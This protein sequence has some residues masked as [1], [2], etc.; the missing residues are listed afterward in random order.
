MKKGWPTKTL[1]EVCEVFADGDWVE[2]KDQSSEGI[3]LIQTGNVGEGVFK[4]RA[5]K[6]RYISDATFKRLR[7]TEIVEGDCLVSRLPDPVGRSC[8][9]PD[10]GERMITAVD[11]T[12]LR[13]NP[14]QL[15]PTFFN[16]YSQSDDYITT[17]AKECTGTTRNRI[18]RSNLGLTPIPVPPLAEQ[19]RIVGLLDEA[20]E[21]IATAK[22]NAEKNLQNARALFESHLQSVFTQRG[23]GWV[24]KPFED[25]I[26]D[27]KYTT[28]IQRKEFLEEG[29]FP[30]VSQEAEFTNGYWDNAA[31][32]F[33]VTRPVV[34]FGD[35]TQ[36]LKYIDFD[37]VLG[38]DGVKLLPP[39]PFLNPKFFFYALRSAPLKSLGYARH[40]RLLKELQ[41]GYPDT[42]TQ[43]SIAK[44]LDALSEETQRLAR[45]YERKHAA[46]DALK[47]SL[48]HQAFSGAL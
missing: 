41:I 21:G 36:V 29:E 15:L 26:E 46:L 34:I 24:E 2:S 47:K 17:V 48:L 30:I 28:K 35:H 37:F 8:I 27:V 31:D 32:V 45:L 19:Q 11:C 9:L 20:F 44:K 39:K 1:G 40:Y 3:R 5:E 6:A 16:L 42:N 22:A 13:F 23:P 43:V 7:C 25:C 33:K 12:I 14:K 4:D 10:T 18:S 38:A